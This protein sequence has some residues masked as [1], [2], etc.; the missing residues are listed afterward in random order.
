LLVLLHWQWPR[1]L[2]ICGFKYVY[3]SMPVIFGIFYL[4]SYIK[5]YYCFSWTYYPKSLS[6]QGKKRE[7]LIHYV[8][9]TS[10]HGRILWTWILYNAPAIHTLYSYY[11]SYLLEKLEW[12]GLNTKS[13]GYRGFDIDTMS[14]TSY[15]KY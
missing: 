11:G 10:R 5:L 2:A 15:L 13:S 14:W 6:W 3:S 4:Y 7:W 1:A 8:S 12:Q 9:S